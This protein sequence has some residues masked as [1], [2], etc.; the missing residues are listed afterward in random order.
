MQANLSHDVV[1]LQRAANACSPDAH[2][3]GVEYTVIATE[4]LTNESRADDHSR[5]LRLRQDANAEVATGLS[6]ERCNSG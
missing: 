2:T 5:I 1:K 3:A 4:Q 6:N